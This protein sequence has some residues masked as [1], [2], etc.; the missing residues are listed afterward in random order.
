MA[1]TPSRNKDE[2][3]SKAGKIA[4]AD[5]VL[6][7]EI[8]DAVRQD[9]FAQFAKRFGVP[10]AIVAV[11]GLAA[12]GGFLF[13]QNQQEAAMEAESEQLVAIIDQFEAGNLSQADEAAALL[14]QNSEGGA[15]VLAELTRA[16]VAV[17]QGRSAEAAAIYGAVADD[18]S[19]PEALRNLARIRQVALTFDERKP[20]DVI[21]TLGPMA[22]PGNAWFGSAGELVALAHLENGD[23]A[24]AG[25]LLS[26]ISKSDEVPASLRARARQLAGLLGVDAIEDVEE[27]LE[28]QGVAPAGEGNGAAGI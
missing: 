13:W 25:A 22:V 17:E 27:L 28:E 24:Q 16:A 6:L 8:D 10:L 5:E 3:G 15:A 21:A 23:Q 11:L 20:S 19:A 14:T 9:D 18:A 4:A 2:A 7:R 1:L 12:F 26:E